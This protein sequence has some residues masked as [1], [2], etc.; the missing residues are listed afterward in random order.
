MIHDLYEL[1]SYK[2][3]GNQKCFRAVNDFVNDSVSV[4]FEFEKNLSGFTVQAPHLTVTPVWSVF[5]PYQW[6]YEDNDEKEHV[7]YFS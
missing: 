4:I 1:P 5:N 2:A 6:T 7:I 3:N